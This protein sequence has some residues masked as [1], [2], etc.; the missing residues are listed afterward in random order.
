VV[1]VLE[2]ALRSYRFTPWSISTTCARALYEH[3]R[4]TRPRT[5][6]DVGSGASTLALAA[7]ASDSGARLVSF[8]HELPHLD[9]TAKALID[10]HLMDHVELRCVPIGD[11][12]AHGF[13]GNGYVFGELPLD[14]DFVFVD[15]P[16]GAI[17][18]RMVLP[19]L[20]NYLSDDWTAWL[21]DGVRPGERADAAAWCEAFGCTSRLSLTEDIRGV[22]VLTP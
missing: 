2:R 3:C 10:A 17:G 16:P 8:E 12:A 13:R 6:V 18:R 4:R 21:H 11:V 5:I 14:I 20:W 7:Y 1:D 19:S 22:L 15:G 9:V